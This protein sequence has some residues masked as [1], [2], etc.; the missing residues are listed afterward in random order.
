M[1][2]FS[3]ISP[4]AHCIR[5]ILTVRTC[6]TCRAAF[7]QF[8]LPILRNSPSLSLSVGYQSLDFSPQL[9]KLS[10]R[11]Q[12]NS[13]TVEADISRIR[14]AFVI[15][16]FAVVDHMQFWRVDVKCVFD[17]GYSCDKARQKLTRIILKGPF[18]LWRHVTD[19][20]DNKESI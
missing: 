17:N 10:Q 4:I 3:L 13:L 11:K 1:I 15:S 20:F 18:L 16:H 9:F 7:I 2:L 19:C 5:A 12:L 8:K 14:P 6:F